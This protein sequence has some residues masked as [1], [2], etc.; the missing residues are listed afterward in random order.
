MKTRLTLIFAFLM[1]VTILPAQQWGGRG[2][3][4]GFNRE[5]MNSG[6]FYGKVVDENG[7]GVAY[8][9]VQLFGMQFDTASKQMVERLIAGQI[10]ED[11]GDFN[12]EKL[13][14]RGDFTLKVS[15]LGYATTEQKVT[16]GLP[17]FRPGGGGPG[18]GRPGAGNWQRGQRPDNANAQK[19]AGTEKSD[20]K[21]T[22][23]KGKEGAEK[24]ASASPSQGGGR[25]SAGG[26]GDWR[27]RMRSAMAGANFDKDLGNIVIKPDA[28]TLDEIV[29]HGEATNVSLSLDKKIFRVDKDASAEGGTAED[30]LKNVPSLSV[31]I[32][33]NLTVRNSS[34]QLFVD[35]RPTTL[36][37]DQIGANEIEQV[38]VITNP[39][40][41]YDASGGQG[42]IVNIVLKKNR[43][44]GY[45]GSIRVGADRW[46]GYNGSANINMREG[47]INAFMNASIFKRLSPSEGETDRQNLFGSPRTN[48][49]Q[50]NDGEFDGLFASLRG[51]VDWFLDNRNTL[52][53]AAN[54]RRGD[55]KPIQDIRTFTDSLFSG[56]TSSSEF[57]RSSDAFRDFENVGASLLFK[58]LFPKKGKEITAD[59]NINT[60][61]MVSGGDF[62]TT[63][64]GS[65]FTSIERQEGTSTSTFITAQADYVEPI[66]DRGKIELGARAA[67]RDYRSTNGNF[68]QDPETGQETRVVN[69]ADEYE[70]EDAVYAAYATYSQEFTQWSYQIGLR[71]ESSSYTGYLPE[72]NSTFENDYP[73]S[74]FPSIFV[75]R[76]I[77]EKDNL[78]ASYTRRVNRPSFFNL[79]PFTDFSDSLNLRRG[80][81]NLL[82]EFTNSFEMTYQNIFDK[83]DNLLITVYYKSATDLITT[84]LDTEFNE[85]LGREAVISTYQNS[86]SSRAYGAE[87]TLRNSITKNVTLTSNL[88][89][90]NSRVDASNVESD[91]I[92]D[93]F[94]WFIKENLSL[95]L[96]KSFTV[97]LNGEYRSRAAF[98]LNSN[99]GRYRGYGR[100]TNTAQGYS[101]E[102]WFVDLSVRKDIMKRKGTLT[103]SIRDIFRS[104]RSG[105]FSES[106]F[107]IQDTWRLRAPQ[108]V[109]LNFSYRF[110]KMDASLFKR[111]NNKVSTEGMELM[112]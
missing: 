60:F 56:R 108:T 32:D 29:V 11:N 89:L 25:P 18:G 62:N 106:E 63:F 112:N 91:L 30:A 82:P 104:R 83:G 22:D 21:K 59:I 86:S 94:S 105:S 9:A 45:N 52:T 74:L 19:S 75:T 64:I 10:T 54:Y 33:G 68:F 67:I 69:F 111:K 61:D 107:F 4:G 102:L 103:V 14:V 77:N 46:G 48:V 90:Y 7:K 24:A 42:G 28:Q 70:F 3:G 38:E 92:N 95:R 47:K 26:G 98:A 1:F 13:P 66:G 31:D 110:G 72:T 40:A 50:A 65:G 5:M 35:G 53:L 97:Q 85:Q 16:F 49:L 81:P 43:K 76:K 2:S 71:A 88:N 17:G 99:R 6:K 93:Q 41:K 73:L 8:A 96:P 101:K 36:T 15:I 58:H 55:M 39:S 87:F 78:Q 79:I 20:E 34:P 57:I 27:S 84:F 37:L 80:N 100:S 44:P 23:K 109:S 12:L 51:G